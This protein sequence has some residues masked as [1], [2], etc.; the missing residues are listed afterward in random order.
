MVFIEWKH[1]TLCKLCVSVC[2]NKMALFVLLQEEDYPGAIQLCLECQKAASTFKHYSCIR[3]S[4]VRADR[5]NEL[6]CI[7][8]GIRTGLYLL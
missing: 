6:S 8:M 4:I 7:Q 3:Y 5:C 1:T 2:F